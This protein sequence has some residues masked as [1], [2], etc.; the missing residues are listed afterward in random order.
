MICSSQNLLFLLSAILLLS[1]LHFVY[2]TAAGEQVNTAQLITLFALSN[3]WM[4]RRQLLEA[5]G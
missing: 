1:G 2:G 5:Q 4:V 3:L